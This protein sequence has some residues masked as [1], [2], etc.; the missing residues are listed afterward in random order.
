[1]AQKI[2]Y[3]HKGRLGK[4]VDIDTL[5]LSQ[6]RGLVISCR[7]LSRLIFFIETE[8]NLYDYEV[9]DDEKI[10]ISD[11]FDLQGSLIKIIYREK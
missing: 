1:M 6:R 8:L 4:L 9:I 7:P 10:C 3:I 5:H 11:A 2:G